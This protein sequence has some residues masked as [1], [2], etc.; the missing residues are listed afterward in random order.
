M[1]SDTRAEILALGARWAEAERHADT[2][3]LNEIAADD[4]RL[5]GPFGFVLD[6]TQWLD[7][8]V[9]G[10]LVTSSLDWEDVEVREFGE[11]AI[12][13]GR[14]T[15]QAT[16]Q[17]RAADGQFRVT[18]VFVRDHGRYRLASLHLS[19][20]APPTRPAEVPDA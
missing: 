13:I 19:Q 11:T 9:S 4:F 14:Q 16:Y 1:T 17:G 10:G 18:H 8:Y 2:K 15:Q 3:I 5:V 20:A 7:R 6:K 12:A